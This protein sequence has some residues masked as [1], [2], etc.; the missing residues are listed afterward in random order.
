MAADRIRVS[1]SGRVLRRR[2][3]SARTERGGA[4]GGGEGV[5]TATAGLTEWHAT[6]PLRTCPGDGM[7]G[8]VV[9][10]PPCCRPVCVLSPTPHPSVRPC[11]RLTPSVRPSVVVGSSRAVWQRAEPCLPRMSASS[12]VPSTGGVPASVLSDATRRGGPQRCHGTGWRPTWLFAP[13]SRL[14]AR[15]LGRAVFNKPACLVTRASSGDSRS[16]G[17]SRRRRRRRR[18]L[19]PQEVTPSAAV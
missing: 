10:A 4:R 15:L 11:L 9:G 3:K 5:R 18:R 19:T 2:L 13:L 12:A 14:F 7:T 8:S 17:A 1:G 16:L 6:P